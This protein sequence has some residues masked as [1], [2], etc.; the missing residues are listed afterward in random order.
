MEETVSFEA[1]C[2]NCATPLNNL[3][4][5]KELWTIGLVGS[6]PHVVCPGCGQQIATRMAPDAE[7][8]NH[9][10]LK[11]LTLPAGVPP[12]SEIEARPRTAE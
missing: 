1:A 4:V 7:G 5:P 8:Q 10:F 9:L 6:G 3:T 11:M 2:P 12:P